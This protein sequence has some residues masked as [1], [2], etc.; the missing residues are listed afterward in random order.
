MRVNFYIF[1]TT[2]AV[3]LLVFMITGSQSFSFQQQSRGRQSPP[4]TAKILSIQ[5]ADISLSFP[6]NKTRSIKKDTIRPYLQRPIDKE[7]LLKGDRIQIHGKKQ[8]DNTYIAFFVIRTSEEIKKVPFSENMLFGRIQSTSPLKLEKEDGVV[9]TI[10]TPPIT[11]YME[12][13][14]IDYSQLSVGD[15]VMLVQSKLIKMASFD[16]RAAGSSN[17]TGERKPLALP[18]PP[19]SVTIKYSESLVK[20]KADSPF[21][22]FDPNM[23][24]F[25]HLSWHNEYPEIMRDLGVHWATYGATFSFGWNL[26]QGKKADEKFTDFRW[27]RFDRLVKQAQA[28]NIHIIGMLIASEPQPGA[29]QS[30]RIS[31]KLPSNL[32]QYQK[33]VR[34]VVERYDHDGVNDMPGLLYPI[35]YWVIEN[36]PMSPVYW[37]G[38]GGDYAKLLM[39]AYPEIKKADPKST[40]ICSMLR[41]TGWIGAGDPREFMVSFF[42]TLSASKEGRPYDLIDQHWLGVSPNTPQADQ[43]VQF[44]NWLDDINQI[45]G[46]YHISQAPFVSLEI[47]GQPSPERNHA[48]DLVKRHVYLLALGVKKVFWSGIRAAPEE[49]LNEKQREDYFR[50]VSLIDGK[51]N[52]KLAYFA[53][54]KLVR[55]LDGANWSATRIEMARDGV[56]VFRFEKSGRPI[57]VAWQENDR[58]TTIPLDVG[59]NISRALL[60][61]SVPDAE[62]GKDV[63]GPENSFK[64]EQIPPTN[65]MIK[66]SLDT[67]PYYILGN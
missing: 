64:S 19:E 36:E 57:W 15:S 25:D 12:E 37:G 59:R 44:K 39:T 38:T 22:F 45:S 2:V 54:Q 48:T 3:F 55:I 52:N 5:D 61:R 43:Y 29:S 8:G 31:P 47:A 62:S 60:I 9:Y 67:V 30:M 63:K 27:E 11:R 34:S 33:Y 1:G 40:V 4:G 53:Y 16:N 58:H 50:K 28:N 14:P 13:A 10:T 6:D 20:E 46:E 26:I 41:A 24:R 42:Q 35:R 17:L 66:L 21:G 51:G 56:F 49:T 23:L 65:G 7:S 18:M 32:V